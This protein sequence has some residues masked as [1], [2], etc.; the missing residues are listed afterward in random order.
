MHMT[1]PFTPKGSHIRFCTNCG[2]DIARTV[3]PGDGKP[4][5]VCTS[6]GVIQYENPKMVV[7]CIP[8]WKDQILL[9][10][11]AIEPRYGYWTLPA[12]FMENGESTAEGAARETI[13]EAG[14]RVVELSPFALIDVPHVHQVHL[15]FLARLADTDFHPGDE[16]LEAKLFTR[17]QLPWND[18]SF[19]T[20]TETLKHFFAD[21][22]RG[23]YGFHHETLTYPPRP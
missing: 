6:C 1:Y 7:G 15:Y 11:R 10:R 12:G 18:L 22:E 13:E 16:S 23:G 9:C 14:A 8:M 21:R 5:A 17:A 4:R 19:R 3:P 20:V 2:A